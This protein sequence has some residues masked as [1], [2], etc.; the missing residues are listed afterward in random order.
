MGWVA[1][2]VGRFLSLFRSLLPATIG[3]VKYDKK[4]FFIFDAIGTFLWGTTFVLL[5]YFLGESWQVV[6]HY[7]TIVVV[8]TFV[9]GFVLVYFIFK[10]KKEK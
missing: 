10:G 6:A 1:I 2:I 7:G 5:G 8:S 9:L 4:K 3:T